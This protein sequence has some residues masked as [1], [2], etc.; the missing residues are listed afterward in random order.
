MMTESFSGLTGDELDAL[1]EDHV[2]KLNLGA[3]TTQRQV[4]M[5][6]MLIHL[7]KLGRRGTAVAAD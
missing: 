7:Q 5:L 4:G 1:N 2:R 6:A 3:L